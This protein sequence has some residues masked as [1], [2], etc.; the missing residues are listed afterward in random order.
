[1]IMYVCNSVLTM[2]TVDKGFYRIVVDHFRGPGKADSLPCACRC[3]CVSEQER[4]NE[5]NF[6][7]IEIWHAG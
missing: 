1:M 5:K 3:V 6:L 7:P 4:L 2:S